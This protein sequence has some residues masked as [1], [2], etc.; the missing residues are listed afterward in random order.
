MK[1]IYCFSPNTIVTVV[2]TIALYLSFATRAWAQV[3]TLQEKISIKLK[4]TTA[5]QV[6][7]EL[8]KRSSYT[9]SY[10]R[11]QLEKIKIKS[12]VFENISLGKAL[13]NLQALAHIQFNML[14]NTIA[15]KANVVTTA[16]RL[17]PAPTANTKPGKLTGVIRND[18]NELMPGVTVQVEPMNKVTT[19]S[20]NG[21]YVLSLPPGTYTLKVSFVGYQ[22]R[23]ITDAV[24]KEDEITDLS[25]VLT[26]ASTQLQAVVVTGGARKE[27]TRSLLMTQK[28][29]AGM[30]NGISAE[31]IRATPDNNTAQVLKRVSGLTVQN[32]KFVT[33]RGVSDRYNNVLINGAT[34]PSTEPHRRN[35]SFDIVPSAL[36]DNVIVNKTAT[37]DLPG[38]FTGGIVQINTKDVPVENFLSVSAGTG[39]NSASSGKDFL[40]Y[41]RDDKAGLGIVDKNRKWFG[42][43]RLMDPVQ[44]YQMHVKNDTA[45]LRRIGSQ[46]PNRWQYN[47]YPY[48]PAQNYQIAGGMNKRFSKSSLGFVAAA[49][50]FNEQLFEGGQA[51]IS[52]QYEFDS[53]RY[54]YNTTIGGLFNTAYKTGKHRFSWKNLYNRRYSNQ[55]DIRSGNY[56]SQGWIARRTGEITLLNE[57]VQTRLEGEHKVTKANVKLDWF[58]DYTSLNREQ[59]DNR[60][61][62]ARQAPLTPPIE[63]AYTYNLND[64]MLFLGGLYAALLKEKK[65]NTGLN[66]SLPFKVLNET[67]LLKVGYS[68]SER[69]AD[70]DNG[71]F[72][73]LGTT[74]YESSSTG[75]PYYEIV[76]QEAFANDD[77]WLYPA[78]T[79]GSSM[80]DGYTGKQVL[81]GTYVMLDLK[82]L[83][84][85]RI[86]GGARYEDNKM[87]MSTIFYSNTTGMPY[88]DDTVYHEKDW[89]PSAN[90]IYSVNEKF[91]IRAAYSKTLAR[92]DFIERSPTIYYDFTELAEVI[93]QKGLEVSRISNYDLRFE[94]Y[95][96]GDEILSASVFY[97]DFDK[98]VERFYFIE[99]SR[100][101]VEYWNLHNATAKGFE[102]DLRKSLG[103]INPANP[104]L[105][106]V[107]FSANYTYL[108]GELKALVT[109][110][111]TTGKDTSYIDDQKRPIQGLS[112]YIING[113]LNY[114]EK[115]WG[116]NVGYN[117]IGRRIVNGGIVHPLIQYEN[118]R[119]VLDLQVNVRPMKQRM[120]I[121][122]NI[123]DILNQSYIIYSNTD[124]SKG[125]DTSPAPNNDPKGDALNESLDLVNYKVKRG[126]GVSISISYKF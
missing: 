41:K 116:F 57:L 114:Q 103:F 44:A 123:S 126:T 106:R 108:K 80:G 26:A 15:I 110:S 27:S 53:E 45:S 94:Y 86:T 93:G 73:I 78:S 100:N 35:F 56:L 121:K 52:N 32:D 124:V 76:R 111:L 66:V 63:D 23:R 59:P 87:N 75:L 113:A 98:P 2:L 50:Y 12:F 21:D 40:S 3:I 83:H 104:W 18:K 89:L 49:T 88:F 17:T 122:L 101:K 62:T 16:E 28:N 84:Q 14:G 24:V 48:T 96:S 118:P 60:F 119:D 19:T 97:K 105:Q 69:K 77:L 82:P 72:R 90:V 107:Y 74:E 37:P 20:V 42:D 91:N 22:T 71:N 55:F 11:D 99:T 115:S 120:E 5:A 125:V 8:D 112:P 38:E 1:K 95:P 33:I 67:Q 30:T 92:P 9:F 61:N 68:W 29:N 102:V 65:R 85:L 4:N 79:K 39:F 117:R 34:L 81:Q 7:E 10:T 47:T 25:V 109:K 70:F 13:E 51:R 46:I 64:K 6:I 58:A 31:Q 43:G 36:V 54:R